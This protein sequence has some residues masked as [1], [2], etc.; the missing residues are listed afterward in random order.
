MY[1][2]ISESMP[3]SDQRPKLMP[4]VGKYV[5]VTGDLYERNG[6]H[7]VVIKKIDEDRS[8]QL[9]GDAFQPE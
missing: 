8:V 1:L 2:P 6:L 3:E 9:Q 5:R 7:A 4:F